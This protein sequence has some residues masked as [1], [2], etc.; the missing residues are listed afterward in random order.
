MRKVVFL[1]ALFGVLQQRPV[2]AADV[3]AVVVEDLAARV[4]QYEVIANHC[5]HPIP[6]PVANLKS[7][8][9]FADRGAYVRGGV[10]ATFEG[11][12]LKGNH[13]R[14]SICSAFAAVRT[15]LEQS[16]AELADGIRAGTRTRR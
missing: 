10:R 13:D 2:A 8:L 11:E 16:A 3:F 9:S 15:D 6:H 7:A 1:A 5:A 14:A 12:R 4:F